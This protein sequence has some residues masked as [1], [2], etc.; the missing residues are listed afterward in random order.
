MKKRKT[1]I[2]C[3]AI[4]VVLLAALGYAV[5]REPFVRTE[6]VLAEG[7]STQTTLYTLDS[8]KPGKTIFFLAGTHGNEEAG[9]EAARKMVDA[10][11]PKAGKILLIPPANNR[12]PS[13]TCTKDSIST[14]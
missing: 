5:L 14:A 6:T 7:L 8:G 9:Y 13:S 4:A 10:L 1:I 12:L 3:A 2:V 11:K